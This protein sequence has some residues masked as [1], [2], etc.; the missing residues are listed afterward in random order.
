MVLNRTVLA[1]EGHNSSNGLLKNIL[2]PQI[3]VN[4]KDRQSKEKSYRNKNQSATG[5]H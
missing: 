4:P 2:S 3:T 1:P 5:T